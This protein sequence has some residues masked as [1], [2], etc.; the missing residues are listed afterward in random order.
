MLRETARSGDYKAS[1]PADNTVWLL[2]FYLLIPVG[3]FVGLWFLFRK[4]RD[5]FFSGGLTG[6]F[7]KS[8]ARRYEGGDK[9]I[10]SPT[11]PAWKASSTTCR[12]SSSSSAIRPSSSGSAPA[13]PRAFC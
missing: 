13:C 10:T 6:G 5:S 7:A 8:G 2:L 12:R 11:W 3:L 1:E 9:P 4:A